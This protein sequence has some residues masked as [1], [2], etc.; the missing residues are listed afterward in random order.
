ML[1]LAQPQ[2]ELV[3]GVVWVLGLEQL[4][5]KENDSMKSCYVLDCWSDSM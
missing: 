1:V 4:E 3:L 2:E 5:Q